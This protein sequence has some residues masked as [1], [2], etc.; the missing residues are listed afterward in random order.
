MS[1]REIVTI[2]HYGTC[3]ISTGEEI[4]E[5]YCVCIYITR[6][7]QELTQDGVITAEQLAE[8]ILPSH[9]SIPQAGE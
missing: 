7:L 2:W 1:E 8:Q 9:T 6:T 4:G 5:A 3:P